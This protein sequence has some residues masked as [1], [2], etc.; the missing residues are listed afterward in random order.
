M[1]CLFCTIEKSLPLTNSVA[2]LRALEDPSC[3]RVKIS[4]VNL[5][6]IYFYSVELWKLSKG[7]WIYVL[8]NCALSRHT[9]VRLKSTHWFWLASCV[10]KAKYENFCR[11]IPP[12]QGLCRS[13]WRGSDIKYSTLSLLT[14]SVNRKQNL[15]TVQF[16]TMC[17][18]TVSN[19]I[20]TRK[21]LNS[22]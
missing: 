15:L 10:L 4:M 21:N 14:M 9:N 12:S 6:F 20:L 3:I 16:I 5:K 19:Q 11:V 8:K 2:I 7:L 13:F 1:S 17:P 18:R 22:Y